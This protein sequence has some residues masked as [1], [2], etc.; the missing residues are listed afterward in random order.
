MSKRCFSLLA[1]LAMSAAIVVV[2]PSFAAA[3]ARATISI[4][5]LTSK[6]APGDTFTIAISIDDLAPGTSLNALDLLIEYDFGFLRLIDAQPGAL[7]SSCGWEYFAYRTWPPSFCRLDSC[8]D[9]KVRLV[10]LA[11]LGVPA[12]HPSCFFDQ[13]GEIALMTFAVGQR[14]IPDC[15]WLLPIRFSWEDCGDNSVTLST[16]TDTLLISSQVFFFDNEVT[17][18]DPFP[19][20][21]GAPN[22]CVI[23]GAPSGNRAR[24]IDFVGSG[25][26]LDCPSPLSSG[27]QISLLDLGVDNHIGDV[28]A[29]AVSLTDVAPGYELGSFELFIKYDPSALSLLSVGF[30]TPFQCGYA[31]LDYQVGPNASCGST[32]CPEGVIRIVGLTSDLSGNP[33]SCY[34]GQNDIIAELQFLIAF[35]SSLLCA[36]TPVEFVWYECG[37]N[38]LTEAP[39]EVLS[40]F[41]RN[42]YDLWGFAYPDTG[43]TFPSIA[44]IADTCP[45]N[46]TPMIDFQSSVV[47]IRCDAVLASRGD[48]N[49]NGIAYEIADYVMFT[50]YLVHGSAALSSDASQQA[51]NS[52]TNADSHVLLL[53]DLI[54]LQRVIVGD[55][56]PLQAPATV[57]GDTALFVQD[58]SQKT[59]S[60]QYPDSLTALYL[61]FEGELTSA[62]SALTD[63]IVGY[64]FDGKHTRVLLAPNLGPAFQP[65]FTFGTGTVLSYTGDATL[66]GVEASFDGLTTIYTEIDIPDLQQCCMRRGN[67]DHDSTQTIDINDA[68]TL[69]RYM[70][71]N[72]APPVCLEEANVNGSAD[73]NIDVSD[74]VYLIRFMFLNGD[75]PAACPSQTKTFRYAAQ[76]P[77]GVWVEGLLTMTVDDPPFFAGEWFLNQL[78]PTA[79][80]GPQIGVGAWYGS[81]VA[82]PDEIDMNMILAPNQ[83][84][85]TTGLRVGNSWL[86]I[87]EYTQSGSLVSSGHFTLFEM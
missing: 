23:S 39:A 55:A 76:I 24:G 85:L 30:P 72:G 81:G 77:F 73:G 69:V 21:N 42:V 16:T 35:D 22:E 60:M 79:L 57:D 40:A 36:T 61:I 58:L 17:S 84:H 13:P 52:N 14:K 31:S 86:G 53:D 18:S 10:L 11:D 70:F 66:I 28:A 15:D 62:T 82:E 43:I 37:D 67:I 49:L 47:L 7:F 33:P 8:P 68:T 9:S 29:V 65:L 20:A 44:G 27:A 87:W 1:T 51:V 71:G 75:P 19:T 48:I 83:V 59:I 50:N 38:A 6:V 3:Q 45:A 26:Y 4:D 64:A 56:V 2:L 34:L 25:V 74:L 5:S 80:V 78:D 32:P 46:P 12:G 54:Y 41:E 63:H